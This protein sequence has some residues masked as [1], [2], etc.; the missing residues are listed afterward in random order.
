M[1]LN[2]LAKKNGVTVI[3]DFGVAPGL[4]NIVIG[5]YYDIMEIHEAEIL[6]GGLPKTRILPF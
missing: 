1:T 4:S 3:C 2:E 5:Y 6:V